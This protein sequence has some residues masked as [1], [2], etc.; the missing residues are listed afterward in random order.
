M[1]KLVSREAHDEIAVGDYVAMVER[2]NG[3]APEQILAK[4][5]QASSPGFDATPWFI[6]LLT[7][8]VLGALSYLA[9]SERIITLGGRHGTHFYEGLAAVG[10]G[11]ALLAG[12]MMALLKPIRS[13]QL[14]FPIAIVFVIAWVVIVVW[15]FAA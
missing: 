15:Y 2:L 9:L 14:H 4:P 13:S 7:S 3:A 12:S 1:N 5:R 10:V 6:A 11:F 8:F